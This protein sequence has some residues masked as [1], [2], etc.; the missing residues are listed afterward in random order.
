MMK[1]AVRPVSQGM[2]GRC[3]TTT[4]RSERRR[5]QVGEV[6][7]GGVV[8]MAVYGQRPVWIPDKRLRRQRGQGAGIYY[9]MAR[10][11]ASIAE[12]H[13]HRVRDHFCMR[14]T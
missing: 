6:T 7:D 3:T 12:G 1:S 5:R 10:I 8:T 4:R 14:S 13:F 2:L 9:T 11:L